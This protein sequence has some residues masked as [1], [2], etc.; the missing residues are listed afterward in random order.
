M[1]EMLRVVQP[2]GVL[3][4]GLNDHFWVEGAVVAELDV[5]EADGQARVVRREH[6]EHLPGAGID[7]WVV[8]MVKVD[9]SG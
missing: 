5:I 9:I 8:T 1:R 3:V 2:G 7:G 4:V 6:G